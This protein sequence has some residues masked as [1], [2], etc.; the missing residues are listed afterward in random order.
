MVSG[1]PSMARSFTYSQFSL[2]EYAGIEAEMAEGQELPTYYV[3]LI[4]VGIRL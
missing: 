1:V 3:A 2:I 4:Y